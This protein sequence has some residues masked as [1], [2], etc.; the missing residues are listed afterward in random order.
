MKALVVIISLMLSIFLLVTSLGGAMSTLGKNETALQ[1]ISSTLTIFIIA[2]LFSVSG[3]GF[4]FGAKWARVGSILASIMG[5]IWYGVNAKI[6]ELPL[7][8]FL[9]TVITVLALFAFILLHPKVK[10]RLK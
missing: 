7:D 3:I 4:L 1:R 2:L 9:I 5:A 6:Y 10:A 8:S